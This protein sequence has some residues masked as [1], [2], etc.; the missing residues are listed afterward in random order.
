MISKQKL[1]SCEAV[2]RSCGL[3]AEAGNLKAEEDDLT[4]EAVKLRRSCEAKNLYEQGM[5]VSFQ[6]IEDG[7]SEGRRK[8]R[9]KS[10]RTEGGFCASA[11]AGCCGPLFTHNG[12]MTRATLH[13]GDVHS[14]FGLRK[15]DNTMG[16][17]MGVFFVLIEGIVP[18]HSW[19][20]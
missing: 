19:G 10:S 3:E 17:T 7:E 6:K 18:P 1:R 2:D 15:G 9:R 4:E 8:E 12:I 11:A 16:N 14:G 13:K 20:I 5:D